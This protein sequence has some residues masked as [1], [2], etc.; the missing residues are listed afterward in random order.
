MHLIIIAELNSSS[1]FFIFRIE[2]FCGNDQ[3]AL[4]EKVVETDCNFY[5][6]GENSKRCGGNWRFNLFSVQNC[7]KGDLCYSLL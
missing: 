6:A 4:K 2:C 1:V 5:C 3:I 7:D